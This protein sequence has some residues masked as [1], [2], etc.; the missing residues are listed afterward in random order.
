[1]GRVIP[2][3]S[4]ASISGCNCA[5]YRRQ[6]PRPGVYGLPDLR[7]A[8]R[9][10]PDVTLVKPLAAAARSPIPQ[11]RRGSVLR[12]LLEK[13]RMR[14]RP[15]RGSCAISRACASKEEVDDEDRR[16]LPADRLGGDM[17]A[18]KAFAQAA[19]SG[20]RPHRHLRPCPRRRSCRPGT[21]VDRSYKE[22]TRSTSRWSPTPISPVSPRTSNWSPA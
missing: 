20:L 11:E 8:D 3:S 6:R 15:R 4:R 2:P 5:E 19:E 12:L 21:Q 13:L 17:G 18:V 16:G 10:D 1:M 14:R 7:S 22:P 9:K